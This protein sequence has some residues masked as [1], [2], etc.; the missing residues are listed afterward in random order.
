MKK[1][2][3][4]FLL[5]LIYATPAFGYYGGGQGFVTDT[6]C[7]QAKYYPVVAPLCKDTNTNYLWTGTGSG[8]VQVGG[9]TGT[10]TGNLCDTTASA[11]GLSL[12]QYTYAQMIAALGLATVATSGSYN[13]L[14]NKP[15][16]N[17][18]PATGVGLKEQIVAIFDGGGSAIPLNSIAY[19]HRDY[20]ISS[21]D[22]WTVT[23]NAEDATP[24][25]IDVY[26]QA[27][28]A[29][30]LP[31]ST[32]CSTGTKPTGGGASAYGNQA[33]WN[34]STTSSAANYD[35][36]FKVITAPSTSTWCVVTLKVTR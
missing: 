25:V 21:I 23:C 30:S 33:A 9:G 26:G 1:I 12:I 22:E 10:C 35:Y 8:V 27:Y 7:N 16:L 19:V 4:F 2:L 36:A 34:C 29:S 14:S 20:A 31:A 5:F 6:N 17:F 24:I 11:N 3:V 28:S 32:L 13:D 18:L 15:S